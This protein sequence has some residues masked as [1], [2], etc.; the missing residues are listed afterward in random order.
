VN[1]WAG[2]FVFLGVASSNY[3]VIEGLNKIS[4]Y[5]TFLG[6]IC[7]VALNFILIP[8]YNGLGAAIATLVSYGVA[9]YLSNLFFPET[10]ALF[11]SMNKAIINSFRISTYKLYDKK[12]V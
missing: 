9:A 5:K 2:I 3:T 12:I 4:F 8:K 10:R 1:I 11:W 7:N 6:A